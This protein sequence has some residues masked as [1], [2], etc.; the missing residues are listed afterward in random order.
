MEES[1]TPPHLITPAEGIELSSQ[2]VQAISEKLLLEKIF[3][4]QEL[5]ML[6]HHNNC[7]CGYYKDSGISDSKEDLRRTIST[8]LERLLS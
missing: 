1:G 4:K 3:T 5:E 2:F 6:L 8:K 7:M